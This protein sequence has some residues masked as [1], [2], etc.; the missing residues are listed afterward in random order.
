MI[1]VHIIYNSSCKHSFFSSIFLVFF[2]V[3]HS[4]TCQCFLCSE[5]LSGSELCC[6]PPL[7]A[8]ELEGQEEREKTC[9]KVVSVNVEKPIA[10]QLGWVELFVGLMWTNRSQNDCV[11]WNSLW[12]LAV[13]MWVE[14]KF[15]LW[16]WTNWSQNVLSGSLC[17]FWLCPCWTSVVSTNVNKLIAKRLCWVEPFVGFVSWA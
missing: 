5:Q 11:G 7:G 1:C 16:M 10:K 4:W 15:F 14:L 6:A 2:R 13:S 3:T 12:V 8:A 9:E 17:G